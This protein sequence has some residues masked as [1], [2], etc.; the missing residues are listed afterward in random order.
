MR[1]SEYFVLAM[2][3]SFTDI[4]VKHKMTEKCKI[5]LQIGIKISFLQIEKHNFNHIEVDFKSCS[6]KGVL[7]TSK[8]PTFS[9][10]LWAYNSEFDNFLY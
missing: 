7:K 3:F 2:L 10:T 9:V 8:T 4:T 6:E 5:S 1:F